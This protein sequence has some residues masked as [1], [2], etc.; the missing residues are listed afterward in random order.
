MELM[1]DQELKKVPT[2]TL[3][4]VSRECKLE[5]LITS[6]E[7]RTYFESFLR[8]HPEINQYWVFYKTV[9]GFGNSEDQKLT[10]KWESIKKCFEDHIAL[11]A[12]SED[13]ID[14]CLNRSIVDKLSKQIKQ[15]D[16]NC[17]Q[18]FVNLKEFALQHLQTEF[19]KSSIPK[20]KE[21]IKHRSS[22]SCHLI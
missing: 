8:D 2:K 15:E 5:A 9:D 16:D 18:E 19:F 14:A 22:K 11:A 20:L 21:E 6:E 10:D 4:K 17:L 12:N 13:R 1:A 3:K 7:G